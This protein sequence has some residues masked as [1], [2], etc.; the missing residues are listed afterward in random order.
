MNDP[1][2][3]CVYAIRCKNT[4]RIYIGVTSDV[5]RRFKQ[6]LND[7]RLRRK[8]KVSNVNKIVSGRE[9]QLD[10]DTFGEDAFEFY[11]LEDGVSDGPAKFHAESKWIREY[12]TCDPRYGYNS[13]FLFER[14]AVIVEVT[15]GVPPKMESPYTTGETNICLL[16]KIKRM[17]AER[18]ETIRDLEIAC[19]LGERTVYR[20]DKVIPA[21]NKVKLVADHFGCTVDD[22][23]DDSSVQEEETEKTDN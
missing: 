18:H 1:K 3:F 14:D 15:P 17:C 2:F 7:L 19:G 12:N 16:K 22:L 5:Q 20:W 23:L 13:Q 10:Y 21:V 4:G 8:E 11:V 6:H 9:W